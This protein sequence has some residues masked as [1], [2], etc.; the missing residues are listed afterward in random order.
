MIDG[1]N[2]NENIKIVVIGV[3]GGG[4]NAVNNMVSSAQGTQ[5][6][7]VVVNT[8]GQDIEKSNADSRILITTKNKTNAG[9]G[10]GAKPEVG[11]DAAEN[12]LDVIAKELE[13]ANLCFISAGLGGGTGTGAAPVIADFAKNQMG[14]TT[15]AAVTTPFFWEGKKRA[16]N[17]EEGLNKLLAATDSLIEIPNDKVVDMS[18]KKTS[19]TEAFKCADNVLRDAVLGITDLITKTGIINLDF[20]DVQAIVKEAGKSHMGIGSYTCTGEDENPVLKALN[21]AIDSP[22]LETSIDGAKRV[23]INYA[24]ASELEM[25]AISE[26]NQMVYDR[27]DED[28]N[29]IWGAATDPTLPEGEVK[30]TVI[31]ADF[32]SVQSQPTISS[33][34]IG[35]MNF[36]TTTHQ[37]AEQ[38]PVVDYSAAFGNTETNIYTGYAGGYTATQPTAQP[39][40]KPNVASAQPVNTGYSAPQPETTQNSGV[41]IPSS[42]NPRKF[43][44][45]FSRK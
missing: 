17:A 8:D 27:A 39:I 15:V 32:S 19:L 45:L 22:L 18:S 12:C 21:A 4:G 25:L 23:M 5:I 7:F 14:I 2:N 34:Q 44:S 43:T 29:L 41:N 35:G 9:L 1:V 36:N 30:V 16:V 40:S 13:G 33:P 38:S 3:G 10:A 31:A 26:A 11:A 6:K 37:Q 24:S 42:F 28:V 20:A